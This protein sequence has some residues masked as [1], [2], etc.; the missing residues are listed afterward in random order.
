M[1]KFLLV[2][3][4]LSLCACLTDPTELDETSPELDRASDVMELPDNLPEAAEVPEHE[5]P[6]HADDIDQSV[7]IRC[8]SLLHRDCA[9]LR[10]TEARK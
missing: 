10:F 9:D 2:S 5:L 8:S 7:T 3:L 1:T 4:S 6:R